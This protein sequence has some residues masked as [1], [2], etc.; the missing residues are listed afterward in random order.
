[1]RIKSVGAE[2][3]LALLLLSLSASGVMAAPNEVLILESTVSSPAINS[4]E[5]YWVQQAG[6][7]PV[8][9][10]NA[11][12]G[13]MT[14]AQFSSYEAI[15]IGDPGCV[16]DT[17]PMLAAIL[18]QATWNAAVDGNVILIGTDEVFH[19]VQGGDSLSKY[20]IQY[21]TANAGSGETGLYAS[22]G[23]SYGPAATPTQVTMLD[24]LSPNGTFSVFGSNCHNA[25][26]I[27]LT[28]PALT[29]LTD[30]ILSD[31]SCSTHEVFDSWP[32]DFVVL[33][34]GRNLGT[35]VAIDGSVGQPYILARGEGFTSV[36]CVNAPEDLLNWWPLDENAGPTAGDIRGTADNGSH[37][38]GPTPVAGKVGGALQFDGVNDQ[39]DVADA[40]EVNFGLGDF[41]I[42]AW[43]KT[44]AASGTVALVDKI[45][46]MS[47]SGYSMLLKNGILALELADGTASTFLSGSFVADGTWHLVAVTVDRASPTGITFYVDGL[48]VGTADPTPH[49]SSLTN[50]VSLV[51]GGRSMGGQRYPGELDEV[52]MFDRALTS[53]EVYTLLLADSLGKCSTDVVV[54]ACCFEN[55]TCMLTLGQNECDELGGLYLG[56]STNCDSNICLDYAVGACCL[57]DGTC[58]DSV[59][60]AD[61]IYV[62]KGVFLG[63]GSECATSECLPIGACCLPTGPAGGSPSGPQKGCAM[64][65]GQAECEL[66]GGIYQGDSTLC[67]SVTC[68]TCV[69]LATGDIDGNGVPLTDIDLEILIGIVYGWA[70]PIDS[71]C[72]ADL[73]GDCAV[74]QEDIDLLEC[75]LQNGPSC[76]T[77]YGGYPVETCCDPNIV[78]GSC[79]LPDTC[80]QYVHD[81]CI[82]G[83]YQGD[84]TKCLPLPSPCPPDTLVWVWPIDTV[85]IIVIWF[86]PIDVDTITLDTV[87]WIGPFD[88]G[89][90]GV[91][92]VMHD[93]ATKGWGTHWGD[94][95]PEG[96]GVLLPLGSFL[97][98]KAYQDAPGTLERAIGSGRATKTG[99]G[100]WQL[101]ADFSSIG[102]A[103]QTV[104][105]FSHGQLIASLQQH[106]GPAGTVPSPPDGWHWSSR[107]SSGAPGELA[108][109]GVWDT[110]V[111][112]HLGFNKDA[113]HLMADSVRFVPELPS[114]PSGF[115]TKVVVSGSKVP[116]VG[117]DG[118]T[119]VTESCCQVRGNANGAGVVNVADLTYLVNFLF[120][121]GPPPPCLEEGD[122]NNSGTIIVSD[123]TYLVNYLFKAGAPPPACD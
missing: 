79:C 93:T 54:G 107:G 77:P 7:T 96:T 65:M 12:W 89:P 118:W 49:S 60:M 122:I 43:I 58:E 98:V 83:S 64:T 74:D 38:G 3:V 105:V 102:A 16:G 51:L 32:S 72:H 40:V 13:S 75:F 47:T 94:L 111:E 92:F 10:N 57:L 123:L 73:N 14:T 9:V 22:L 85:I 117:F 33:A 1:M 26:H 6:F 2:V 69:C 86:P 55:T 59:A 90:I 67:D 97:Q 20:G 95:E 44:T 48:A 63:I 36:N 103:T 110:P 24:S 62:L 112:I 46:T 23:C 78:T 5:Y 15:V 109:T 121:A 56:D 19:S 27:V 61:C 50:T 99:N 4:R 8:V 31:W 71:M 114:P 91:T 29:N 116:S 18:N 106:S 37:V 84:S 70:P 30:S 88:P 113:M 100:E 45:D 66:M 28:H 41:S 119:V 76:F 17:T 34:I 53:F 39:V 11:A 42:D 82:E 87:I 35:Y 81:N 108:C 120:K 101:A 68:D 115:L 52:E 21:V 80:Y 25:S 104:Q